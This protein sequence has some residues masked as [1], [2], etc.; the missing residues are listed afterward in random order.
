MLI[1]AAILSPIFVGLGIVLC[2]SIRK[3]LVSDGDLPL[4]ADWI[5]DLSFDRYRPMLRLLDDQ[6]LEL[7]RA[8]PG[9]RPE[10]E[11]QV[12]RQRSKMFRGYLRSLTADFQRVCAVIKLLILHSGNDRPDLASSLLQNQ[13]LF[14]IRLVQVEFSIYLYGL[15]CAT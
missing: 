15:D 9:F 10:M 2:L 3:I 1:L 11:R 14:A 13:I 8:Q 4:T 12:R 6:D 7:M 5:D